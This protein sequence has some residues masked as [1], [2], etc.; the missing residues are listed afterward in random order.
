MTYSLF[1]VVVPV[2]DHNGGSF[3]GLVDY[4]VVIQREFFQCQSLLSAE[5]VFECGMFFQVGYFTFIASRVSSSTL[6]PSCCLSLSMFVS[7]V[8]GFLY[9]SGSSLCTRVFGGSIIL[10]SFLLAFILNV[11]SISVCLALGA[12]GTKDRPLLSRSTC[13]LVS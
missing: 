13:V 12:V 6:G 7:C 8:V 1:D 4:Q 10:R 9:R 5:I 3:V 2:S 11:L